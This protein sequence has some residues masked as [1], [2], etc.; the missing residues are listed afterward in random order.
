MILITEY[1]ANS[2][3]LRRVLLLRSDIRLTPSDIAALTPICVQSRVFRANR[4]SLKPQGFNITVA[5]RQYHSLRQQRISLYTNRKRESISAYKTDLFSLSLCIWVPRNEVFEGECVLIWSKLNCNSP[6]FIKKR[7]HVSI[8]T[9]C[10]V[11]FL[12]SARRYF[13]LPF[14]VLRSLPSQPSVLL[15]SSF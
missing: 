3:R 15:L 6:V 12:P 11:L 8:F 1:R 2:I 4:I 5:V 9:L 13:R 7:L 14:F 10:P